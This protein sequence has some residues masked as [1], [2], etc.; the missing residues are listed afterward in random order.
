MSYQLGWAPLAERNPGQG[1]EPP[2]T[3][4][5]PGHYSSRVPGMCQG[6]AP[7]ISWKC[8]GLGWVGP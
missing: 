7:S 3:C 1:W 4:P 8:S 6:C 5:H 2:G